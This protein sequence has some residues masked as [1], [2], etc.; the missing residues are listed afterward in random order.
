MSHV[1]RTSSWLRLSLLQ[2][3][4]YVP[5]I[6]FRTNTCLAS[7]PTVQRDDSF[8]TGKTFHSSEDAPTATEPRSEGFVL[9]EVSQL[10]RPTV[11]IK[12]QLCPLKSAGRQTVRR[13]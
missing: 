9:I 8:Y 5:G 1:K 3:L 13:L 10:T 11:T 7:R 4:E 2:Y 6:Y 12:V